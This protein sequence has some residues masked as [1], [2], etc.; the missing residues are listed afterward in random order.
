MGERYAT[1]KLAL[2]SKLLDE[3]YPVEISKFYAN[4]RV[5]CLGKERISQNG[6]RIERDRISEYRPCLRIEKYIE[7]I[8]VYTNG[9]ID[10]NIIKDIV[11]NLFESYVLPYGIV[12][13]EIIVIDNANKQDVTI[14]DIS[15]GKNSSYFDL[16]KYDKLKIVKC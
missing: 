3:G 12:K 6:I 14:L 9:Y 13:L 11:L 1:F 8:K 15:K 10:N 7:H 5:R 4:S 16:S 2:K